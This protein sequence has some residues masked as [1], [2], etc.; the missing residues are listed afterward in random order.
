MWT[1]GSPDRSSEVRRPGYDPGKMHQIHSL[2]VAVKVRFPRDGFFHWTR[3]GLWYLPCKMDP[4]PSEESL[5]ATRKRMDRFM[6]R[7]CD[8]GAV[9]N[10]RTVRSVN[11]LLNPGTLRVLFTS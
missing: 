5:R 7:K 3:M 8:A 4:H 2:S 10:R 11:N 9:N 6:P 1:G